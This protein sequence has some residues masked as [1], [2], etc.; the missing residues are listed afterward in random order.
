MEGM[1]GMEGLA[2][3]LFEYGRPQRIVIFSQTQG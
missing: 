3:R 2:V 1:E